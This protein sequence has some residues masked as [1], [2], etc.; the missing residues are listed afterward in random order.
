ML[1]QELEE[2]VSRI[3]QLPIDTQLAGYDLVSPQANTV[4]RYNAA[5]DGQEST[6][7]DAT[8]FN[9]NGTATANNA[10]AAA[11]SA[12]L[13]YNWAQQDEDIEVAAGEYS[14]YHW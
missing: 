13:A 9:T 4:I 11:A 14:A 12:D 7:I 8:T 3:P 6:G 5:L 2:T 1:V 10:I